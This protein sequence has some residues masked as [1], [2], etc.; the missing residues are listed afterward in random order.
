MSSSILRLL[1]ALL[2]LN[3][4]TQYSVK[5]QT[6]LKFGVLLPLNV[7]LA[8]QTIRRC[9]EL[10]QDTINSD[11]MFTTW[12]SPAGTINN[13][14]YNLVL[15][16]S[17]SSLSTTV[18]N[19]II[20]ANKE[21]VLAIVGEF[22]SGRTMPM[23]LA[24]NTFGVYNCGPNTNPD[25][26]NKKN[27]KYFFRTVPSDKYQGIQMVKLI[28]KFGWSRV[29]LITVNSAYGFGMS[30]AFLDYANS[31][32]VAVLRNE[33]YNPDDASFRVQINSIKQVDARIIVIIGYDS[34]SINIMREARKQG[35]VGPNYVWLGSDGVESMYDLVYGETRD[36]YTDEDR[37]NVEGM[38][39]SAIYEKG[40]ARYE[41][42]NAKYKAKYGSLPGPFSYIYSDCLLSYAYGFKNLYEKKGFTLQQI[43]NRSTGVMGGP[44]SNAISFDGYSGNVSFDEN[45]DRK[46]G[47]IYKTVIGGKEV[48]TFLSDFDGNFNP[49]NPIV[50]RGGSTTPPL[51]GIVP[52]RQ[53][54][55]YTSGFGIFIIIANMLGVAV[56]VISAALLILNRSTAPV[57]Q[58][59]L[60]FLLLSCAGL[61][62]E[63]FAVFGW[64]GKFEDG[65]A[66]SVQQWLGWIG[67]SVV[68]Q[69]ILPKC[70]RIFR[71][72]DNK[73]VVNTMTYLKDHYLLLL[74]IPITAVNIILIGI[75][76]GKDPLTATLVSTDNGANFHYEC[77]SISTTTQDGFNIALM[78]YNAILIGLAI[79]LAYLTRN[80]SSSYRE[81]AFI[82]YACQNILICSVVVIALVYSSGGSFMATLY[83]RLVMMWISTTAVFAMTVGRTTLMVIFELRSGGAPMFKSDSQKESKDDKGTG[84][85]V[86]GKSMGADTQTGGAP[87]NFTMKLA[88]KDG[89]RTL[90]TWSN[91]KVAYIHLSKILT[92]HD[93]NSLSG[94]SFQVG[95]PGSKISKSAVYPDCVDLRFGNRFLIVQLDGAEEVEKFLKNFEGASTTAT[96]AKGSFLKAP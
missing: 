1:A 92:I 87:G 83:L 41:S 56:V 7:P 85:K 84:S 73:R 79:L 59:S 94:E 96:A 34:D 74:S 55:E 13:I 67:F 4:V 50:F 64:V 80:T 75:W 22:S 82:L 88:V 86:H 62:L 65:K 60:P 5:A 23:A 72:F 53:L 2:A 9:I 63:Y 69:G 78:I 47:Y 42:L 43:Q 54:L 44:F 37:S 8:N 95:A 49:I 27:Y 77:K 12:T 16:D 38:I 93:P 36:Q 68:M 11:P 30:S 17:E 48:D 3:V 91:K 33:A 25:L 52:I 66:C 76:V 58:M 31:Q 24:L 40:N 35:M 45:G 20:L 28:Q 18:S 61:I 71:I 32:N 57:R 81:T 29:A 6:S 90:S 10:T 15:Y 19:G 46:I 14:S 70:W 89:S 26:S 39:Y 21:N 51:D